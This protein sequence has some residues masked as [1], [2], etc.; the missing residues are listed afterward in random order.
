MPK[1]QLAVLAEYVGKKNP[2]EIINSFQEEI[3][4]L[5][6]DSIAAMV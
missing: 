4:D 2:A 6:G 3:P 1:S 5:A